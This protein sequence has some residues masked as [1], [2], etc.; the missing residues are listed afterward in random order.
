MDVIKKI[1]G[2]DKRNRSTKYEVYTGRSNH[3]PLSTI[4]LMVWMLVWATVLV[5]G[6]DDESLDVAA[7]EGEWMAMAHGK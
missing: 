1:C 4:P 3:Q 5:P 7:G 2:R 6:S